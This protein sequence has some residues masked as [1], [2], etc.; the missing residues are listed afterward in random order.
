M[1][2]RF[3][4]AIV[5]FVVIVV[6]AVD[7]V[8]AIVGAHVLAG[9]VQTDEHLQNRPSATIKGIPFLTQA[10]GG[11][12]SDI[13]LSDHDVMVNEVPVTT[14]TVDL[15]GVH[16]PFSKI[17]GGSVSEVPV[18]RVTGTAFVSYADANDYLAHHLPAG[19][20]VRLTPGTDGRSVSMVDRVHLG[21]QRIVLRGTGTPTVSGNT[22]SVDTSGLTPAGAGVASSLLSQAVAKVAVT[23]PLQA[24]P[25]KLQ[26]TRLT[27]SP[28]GLT[29]TGGSDHIV[30][31]SGD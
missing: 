18:D 28:S 21:G 7:R 24:L 11:K 23:F 6:I 10:F 29:G 4:L 26:L 30:L 15:H 22:V 5:L 3:L 17:L 8:G 14:L 12:Y 19:V 2:R 16:L 25:F 9:K 31:G 1:F 13:H 20:S 27:I